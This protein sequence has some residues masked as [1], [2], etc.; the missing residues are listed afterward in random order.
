MNYP[1]NTGYTLKIYDDPYADNVTGAAREILFPYSADLKM[2]WKTDVEFN[3]TGQA[4]FMIYRNDGQLLGKT[5]TMKQ[6]WHET[7]LDSGSD[8]KIEIKTSAP[9]VYKFTLSFLNVGTVDVPN[10]K[11]N[12]NVE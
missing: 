8:K 11:Y 10:Y 1:E 2:P 5:Y 3:F 12:I 6:E 7:D 9:G 4:W